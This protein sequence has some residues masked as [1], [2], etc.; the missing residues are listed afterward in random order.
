MCAVALVARLQQ[1][2]HAMRM[3]PTSVPPVML[4]GIRKEICA[5]QTCANVTAVLQLMVLLARNTG[6]TSVKVVMLVTMQSEINA[7]KTYANA[8]VALR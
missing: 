8:M 7:R 4:A 1:E 5:I 6:I 3:V 2:P